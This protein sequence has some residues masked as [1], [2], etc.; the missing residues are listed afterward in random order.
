MGEVI[1]TKKDSCRGCCRSGG[2][3]GKGKGY[4]CALLLLYDEMIGFFHRSCIKLS[5]YNYCY[6]SSLFFIDI[7]TYVSKVILSLSLSL[8]INTFLIS[9]SLILIC[10]CLTHQSN[11]IHY[12]SV[13]ASVSIAQTHQPNPT[14]KNLNSAPTPPHPGHPTSILPSLNPKQ[15]NANLGITVSMEIPR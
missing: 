4:H 15:S 9:K 13:P 1:Q 12:L 8:L 7:S 10:L 5:V 2:M 11:P 3:G 14:P 6:T